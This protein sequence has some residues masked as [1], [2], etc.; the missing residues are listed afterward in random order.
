MF[1]NS[2]SE[3]FYSPQIAPKIKKNKNGL[4]MGEVVETNFPK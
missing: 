2:I 3:S 1:L 4:F